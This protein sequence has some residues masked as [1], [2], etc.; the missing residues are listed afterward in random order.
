MHGGS[1]CRQGRDKRPQKNKG[2]EKGGGGD[3]LHRG[4]RGPLSSS[5]PMLLFLARTEDTDKRKYENK[6][7]LMMLRWLDFCSIYTLF[8]SQS[9]L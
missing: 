5:L 3:K 8:P 2:K 7:D 9:F 1:I 4:D 6:L